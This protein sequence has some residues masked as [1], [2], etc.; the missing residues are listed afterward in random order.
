[1]QD[2]RM[3]TVSYAQRLADLA[4]ADPTH[5]AVTDEHRS[6]TRAELESLA[7]RTARAVAALG[8]GQ[9]DM[10]TIALP[11]SIEFLAAVVAAWK[12]GATPQPVSSRL[13]KRELD[14]IIELASPKVVV[15]PE[16]EEPPGYTCLP[17]GWEPDPSVDDG[18]LPDATA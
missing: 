17:L 7:N 15:A 8:V 14:G 9:G 2:G 16:P 13:P 3:P 5:L 4:T 10:V 18:P 11:N 12:L 6:V 1:M